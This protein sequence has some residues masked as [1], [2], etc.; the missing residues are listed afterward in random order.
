[1]SAV[2][3][4]ARR[5]SLGLM[6]GLAAALGGAAGP[7]LAQ[8]GAGSPELILQAREALRARDAQRLAELAGMTQAQQHALAPWVDYWQLG[9][10]LTQATQADLEA[11]YARWPGSYVED[12]MRNDWLL[13]LG[14]RRDWKNFALDYPRFRMNDDREVT[15]YALLTE[16]LAGRDVRKEA[17]AAWLAQRDGDDGCQLLAS[18]LLEAKRL[19]E[20]DVWLKLRLATEA[21]RPRAMQGAARL[22]GKPVEAGVKDIIDN[23]GRYL[24]RKAAASNRQQDELTTVALV[25]S[26]SNDVD[27]TTEF[28][29]KR[30]ERQLPRDNAAWVWAQIGRA[31]AFRLQPE[32][33]DYYDK[34]LKLQPAKQRIEWS[35]ET[36]AWA[37]RAALRAEDGQGRTALLLRAIELLEKEGNGA[38][39]PAW[40]YWK[41]RSLKANP[42]TAA[43]ARGLL[44][45]LASPLSFYGKLAAEELGQRAALPATPLPLTPAERGQAQSHAGLTRAL[46]LVQLGL[47]GEGV[48]EW[49]F[50]LRGMG[51]R[52]LLAAAQLACEREI[53]DRCI[54]TSER[55]RGEVDLAQRYPMPYRAELLAQA[56]EAGLDPAYVY[57]LIR[58]ESRFV[59]DAR[60]HVGASGLMQV[61]PSTAKWTA[62]K[63]GMAYKPEFLTDRDFNLRIGTTY[64]KLVLDAFDGSQALAAAAY[65]AGPGRPRRWR[66]GPP[67]DAAI[68]AESIP[69]TETRDYVKRVLSNA[70]IYAQLMGN[71]RAE[72]RARLGRS[73]GPAS[74]PATDLP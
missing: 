34:A 33:P 52:E 25:R 74:A 72:L 44:Q 35:D 31:A 14:R 62:K 32:A 28:M 21:G 54:N 41:A 55:T 2:Y 66:D 57:G 61:M 17:K 16:H 70:T 46:M 53:W 68:W 10:R 18:T 51:D 49:N 40:T 22:L 27:A 56:R 60:S 12:R 3:E 36:L 42:Q 59:M 38:L 58:Q 24:T 69:F 64:L 30:W 19:D 67:L 73:I 29:R 50:S 43:E 15:C 20:D 11:F 13:E 9:L 6:L 45:G 26:A 23:A 1:M 7:G 4:G 48:R 39:D 8:T 47:R 63:V 71:E 5:R 37:A 65:N